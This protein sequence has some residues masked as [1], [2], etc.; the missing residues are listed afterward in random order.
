MDEETNVVYIFRLE[1]E[2]YPRMDVN[3]AL[4]ADQRAR[5]AE[6]LSGPRKP[7]ITVESQRL[8]LSREP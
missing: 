1:I 8:R 6:W 2:G 7:Q 3:I 5:V 4:G